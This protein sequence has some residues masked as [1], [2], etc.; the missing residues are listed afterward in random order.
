TSSSYNTSTLR[1]GRISQ[2]RH[3][4]IKTLEA[5]GKCGIERPL[6]GAA[7]VAVVNRGSDLRNSQID[8]RPVQ[9]F[10]PARQHHGKRRRTAPALGIGIAKLRTFGSGHGF[11]PGRTVWWM[12]NGRKGGIGEAK[13]DKFQRRQ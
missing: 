8:F 3:E 13:P 10:G 9:N 12:R 6:A 11:S 1:T 4:C 5:A 7:E 2:P